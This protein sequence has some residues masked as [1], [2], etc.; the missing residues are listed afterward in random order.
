MSRETEIIFMQVRLVRLA[1]EKW[2]R[3][4]SEIAV[5][6]KDA[7]VY[8]FI[9]DCYEIF[10]CEG[11]NAVFEDVAKLVSRKGYNVNG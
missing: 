5:L 1:S 3:S 8:K 9:E 2:N 11:D 6:F 10:H 7:G 4:I